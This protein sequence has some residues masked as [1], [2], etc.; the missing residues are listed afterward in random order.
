MTWQRFRIDFQKRNLSSMEERSVLV[1][2]GFQGNKQQSS[3]SDSGLSLGLVDFPLLNSNGGKEDNPRCVLQNNF[4]GNQANGCSQII[5]CTEDNTLIYQS[6]VMMEGEEAVSISSEILHQKIKECEELAIGYFVGRK[7][8]YSMAKEATTKVWKT[9]SEVSITLHSSNSFVFK[10]LNSEDRN[11][12]LDHGAFY[13]SSSL[14]VVRPW[15]PLI[16]NSIAEMKSIPVWVLIYNVPLH[17]WNNIGLSPIAS[18]VGKPLMMDDCT[19]NKTRLSY[20]RVLVEISFESQFP[21]FI[22]LWIDGK[23][24]MNLPVEYQWKPQKCMV[25]HS[26]GHPNNK[27]YLKKA[28]VGKAHW[29]S[30]KRPNLVERFKPLS[31]EW[32]TGSTDTENREQVKEH[33]IASNRR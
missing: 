28:S 11:L 24:V 18:F 30:K 16:E 1:S 14:F 10:F 33:F 6:P 25:C 32:E 22:P 12:A 29:T 5:G 8:S 20:A 19:I 26:F 3:S 13:I 17:L 15:S 21:G 7:H 9:K 27:C 31:K 2:R 4:R 23:Y